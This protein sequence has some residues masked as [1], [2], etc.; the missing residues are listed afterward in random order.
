MD[1]VVMRIASSVA[2]PLIKKLFQAEGP[3]AGLVDRPVRIASYVSFKGE[4]RTL[5]GTDMHDLAAALVKEAFRTEERPAPADEEWAVVD[6]L[7]TTLYALGDLTLSDVAAVELGHRSL[8]RELRRAADTPERELSADATYFYERLLETACLH[9]LNF[10]TQRSTFI[11]ATLV[12]QSRRQAELIALIDELIARN[13]LPGSADAA[14][15]SRYREHI[16]QKHNALTIYGID[17]REFPER[18]PLDAAY[19]SLEA[20]GTQP[21]S[22]GLPGEQLEPTT[23]RLP[24]EEAFL[25]HERVL[26]RGDAGSGKTTLV[27]W[28][29]ITA[30]RGRIPFV[31]PL[32]TLIRADTLPTPALFLASVACPHTPPDGWAERVLR[33]R[34][35][36]VMVDGLDEIPGPDRARTKSWLLDLTTAFPGNHWLVT[37]RP[38]AV[39]PD[40]LD[41]FRELTLAPMTSSDVAAFVRRWHGAADAAE[42]EERLLSA[43]RTRPGLAQLATNPLM[44]GLICALFRERRGFLPRGRKELYDAALAMLL[45]RRDMERGMGAPD[46]IDLGTEA[47]RSL[48]Q[49]IAYALILSGRTEMDQ[50]DATAIIDRNLPSITTATGRADA[51]AVFRHLLLRSGLLRQPADGIVNFVHRTFLDYLG[52]EAAVKDGHLDVLASR[53]ADPTWEDVIR[54]AVAHARPHER[55]A[56]LAKLKTEADTAD[57]PAT[58]ARLRLLAMA[59]LEDAPELDPRVRAEVESRA[60]QLIPPS[61]TAE[62]RILAEAGPLVLELLP[63]PEG[64]TDEEALGVT[65]TASRIAT[66]AALPVLKSYRSH[67]NLRVRAQLAGTWHRFDADEYADEVIAHL[68]PED[69]QLTI[70]T[71]EQLRTLRRMAPHHSIALIGAHDVPDALAVLHRPTLSQLNIRSNPGLADVEPL[72]HFP[73]LFQ[74]VLDDCPLVS[75]LSPLM[76]TG[77]SWLSISALRSL[78]NL[79][80]LASLS[81]LTSLSVSQPLPGDDLS[82]LPAA[83]PLTFLFLSHDAVTDTGLRGLGRWPTLTRLSLGPHAGRLTPEDWAEVASLPELDSLYLHRTVLDAADSAPALPHV[84]HLGINNMYGSEDL[85]ALARLFPNLRTVSL[86]P[87]PSGRIRTAERYAVLFPGAEVTISPVYGF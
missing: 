3:G 7:T 40:W 8:A 58:N 85:S 46:G 64:L 41:G 68:A 9:I 53:A 17:L 84:T 28:L 15:E 37:S 26:L 43:L 27:Q 1:P 32:R 82:A 25:D 19:L 12:A 24:A 80:G 70:T 48:L 86:A 18:W 74:L 35:A 11:P 81:R 44:C 71:P 54:M 36:L 33:S 5:T 67:P 77:I 69:L 29:A 66:D 52:A 47:R 42:Y 34:R 16:T 4:K 87:S 78:T 72:T 22:F 63:G 31:L 23:V 79:G 57:D 73:E 2:S 38:T 65:I 45:D 55:T 13:P 75:D 83:A 39:R 62:A 21:H 14:F 50:Q 51:P 56:I 59:C 49:R 6:A 76:D 20:T 30:D 10:F 61:T 60:A